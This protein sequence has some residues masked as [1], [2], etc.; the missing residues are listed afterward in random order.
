MSRG[1]NA[2]L[3]VFVENFSV[4]PLARLLLEPSPCTADIDRLRPEDLK[5]MH[6]REEA[7]VLSGLSSFINRVC[8]YEQPLVEPQESHLRHV[9]LRTIVKLPHSEQLSPS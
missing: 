1:R 7:G 2:A 6:E 5:P 4:M 8:P 9:P 3:K